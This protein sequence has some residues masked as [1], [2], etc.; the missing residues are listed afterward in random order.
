MGAEQALVDTLREKHKELDAHFRS[1]SVRS[2]CQYLIDHGI[3]EA[4][5]PPLRHLVRQC[6]QSIPLSSFIWEVGHLPFLVC[7]VEVGYDYEGNGTDFWPKLSDS[8]GYRCD[9]EDRERIST[10]FVRAASN[11][12]AAAPGDSHWEKAFRHIAWPITHAV[13]ARDIRRP[14][15]DC[16]KR[17]RGN[18]R[19]TSLRDVEIVTELSHISTPVSSRRFRTWLAR[20]T[21]V[22][23]IVRDLLGGMPLD[24]AGLFSKQFRDR[25]I[26]DLQSEPEIRAAVRH[27]VAAHVRTPKLR[28]GND[29]ADSAAHINFGSLLLCGDE[30]AGFELCGEMPELPTTVRNALKAVRGRWKVR[31]WGH[32]RA[33]PIPA[34][35]LR[36]S[37]GQFRV[38][39][40]YVAETD[41]NVAFFTG[42]E[43]LPVDEETK[44]WLTSVRF[45]T[46]AL[47]AFP[48]MQP[49]DDSTH[50]ITGRR[51]QQGKVWVLSRRGEVATR[52]PDGNESYCRLI[53]YIDNGELHEFN[54]EDPVIREWLGWPAV[55]A[56]V[57]EESNDHCWIHPSPV[58][59]ESDYPL[60]TT[61]DEIGVAVQSDS[62]LTVV[63]R[64]GTTEVAREQVSA[65]A[66]SRIAR[67]GTYS[68]AV[69]RGEQEIDS[70]H[71]GIVNDEGAAFVEPVVTPPW[72]A[73]VLHI[74]AGETDLTRG[75]F[76]NRRLILDVDGDRGIENLTLKLSLN[77]GEAVASLPIAK[78][79]TRLNAR[80]PIWEELASLLPAS[81]LRSSLDL[82]LT[83]DIAGVYCNSWRLEAELQE[84]WWEDGVNGVPTA[85]TDAGELP[86]RH[87]SLLDG[88]H[89]NKPTNG[90]PFMSVALDFTGNEFD[91][92][93]RVGLLGDATLARSPIPPKRFLRGLEQVGEIPGL[94]QLAR[95]YLQ[96]STASSNSL[97]AEVNR[98]GIAYT[99]KSW[100]L[101]SLCG[102]SWHYKHEELRPL[103]FAHPVAVWWECQLSV[104]DRLLLPSKDDRQLPHSLPALVLA[105]FADA[106]PDHWW[107][108]PVTGLDDDAAI[109][110]DTLYQHL[111]D[112]DSV[113]VDTETLFH[114]LLLAN[115]RLCGGALADLIIPQ[116]GG[117]ELLKWQISE[118][119]VSDLASELNEWIRRHLGRG[120]GRHNWTTAELGIYLSLLLYPERLRNENWDVILEKLLQDRCVARAGAFIAWRVEQNARVASAMACAETI[121][122]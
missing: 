43:D 116:T 68:L 4:E 40:R 6:L 120:R 33:Q 87:Y 72:H 64:H 114:T 39:F 44:Q 109:P 47:L 10:W 37:Q 100:V 8:L 108:G 52:R 15:A 42:V 50:V 86:V 115:E 110:L 9:A 7:A 28:T 30:Y 5:L 49:G 12:G 66:I 1:A 58:R 55:N 89:L 76:F 53:G 60:F 45:P 73:R 20:P 90:T 78:I 51:P 61:D 98:V 95:K 27:A 107:D 26:K 97:A 65:V 102:A 111:I 63:L 79:P 113:F 88:E 46:S 103:E 106:L 38:S 105:E 96:I 74:D 92:D 82:S 57:H 14:F 99:F 77:P 36:S 117:D 91:F 70:F 34:D 13:A 119:T 121:L 101:R 25:I 84:L 48:P 69:V 21:V 93:A 11:Y 19:S 2:S 62:P 41:P 16:L 32:L 118:M 75:D 81:T 122:S 80:H 35:C 17:F 59:I 94:Q 85:M 56:E 29:A 22:A 54:A 67:K 104:R 112:D 31:P 3:S 83:V 71:F 18:V 23:G 24:E